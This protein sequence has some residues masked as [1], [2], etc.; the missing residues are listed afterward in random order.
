MSNS[1]KDDVVV[2]EGRE[3][4]RVKNGLDETQVEAFIDELVRQRDKLAQAQDHIGSLNRLAERA[5][6]EADKLAA[7]IK[8]EAT[9]QAKA[10]SAAIIDKAREQ[11]R[12]TTEKKMAEAVALAN[13]EASAIRAKAE[14]EAAVLLQNEK[15]RIRKELRNLVNEQ[16][17]YMLDELDRLKQ[18]ATAV[19][20]DFGTK[21]SEPGE[22]KGAVAAKV[23]QEKVAPPE[24]VMEKKN[25]RLEEE[26]DETA[27]DRPEPDQSADQVVEHATNQADKASGLPGLLQIEEEP[28]LGKPQWEVEILPPFEIAKIME[29]VSFLDQ[30]PEVANT[31]MIVP[32]I[33][34]PLILVFLR[35]PMNVVDVLQKI[36]AVASVEPITIDKAATN[37]RPKKVRISLSADKKA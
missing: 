4:K 28:E 23:E 1:P 6:V 18:Q 22:Q 11:A 29:V 10:E 30:L 27:I 5:I 32:Q 35:K 25:T 37:G 34:V 14:E 15:N 19:Q 24:K 12:Q 3:F 31:E 36:P 20:V 13:E 16:F 21:L 17:G 7:Q 9:E 33:D 8:T 2:L 26:R